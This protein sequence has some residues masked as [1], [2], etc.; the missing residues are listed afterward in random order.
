MDSGL[1]L[2]DFI[3]TFC[4]VLKTKGIYEFWNVFKLLLYNF[5][6]VELVAV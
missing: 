1:S 5:D 6:K 2:F 3:R 4:S